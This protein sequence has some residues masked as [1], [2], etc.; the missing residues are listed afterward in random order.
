MHSGEVT[1][2]RVR[3]EKGTDAQPIDKVPAPRSHP[4]VRLHPYSGRK[5]LYVNPHFTLSIEGMTGEE[6]APLLGHLYEV[7][8][9][10]EH[11]Y[12]HRWSVGDVVMWDNRCAMH[13]GVYDYDDTMPRLMHRTTAA[14][15]VPQ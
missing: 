3:N 5:A 9:R 2:R 12:R 6:S 11:V 4:I 14:G 13:Y 8:T 7:A 15:E 1:A 10:P